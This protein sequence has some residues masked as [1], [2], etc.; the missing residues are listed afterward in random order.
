MKWQV[1]EAMRWPV[2]RS[3]ADRQVPGVGDGRAAVR[4]LEMDNF[5]TTLS[6]G[7][8][9]PFSSQECAGPSGWF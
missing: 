5:L 8:Q 3:R 6:P 7:L 9:S 2:L 4:V 1:R